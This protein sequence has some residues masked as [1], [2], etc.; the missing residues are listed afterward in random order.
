M[1]SHST[2]IH[3]TAH[4]RRQQDRGVTV[5]GKSEKAMTGKKNQYKLVIEWIRMWEEECEGRCAILHLERC[6]LYENGECKFPDTDIAK[7]IVKR[8][9]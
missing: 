9:G 5:I 8:K 1:N 3:R 4:K 6:P 7:R 2:V